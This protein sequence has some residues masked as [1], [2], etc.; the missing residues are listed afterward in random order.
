MFRASCRW[1]R[2]WLES[3]REV[4]EL[5]PKLLSCEAVAVDCE[6]VKLSRWG[7]LCLMQFAYDDD[8]VFIDACRDGMMPSIQPFLES[9]VGPAKIFHDCR[10]DAAALLEQFGIQLRNVYD[11]QVAYT[12]LLE[13]RNLSPYLI[14]LNGLLRELLDTENQWTSEIHH[15]LKT[16]PNIKLCRAGCRPPPCAVCDLVQGAERSGGTSSNKEGRAVF[17]IRLHKSFGEVSYGAQG[18]AAQGNDDSKSERC[19]VFQTKSR[20]VEKRCR[21]QNRELGAVPRLAPRRH[22]RRDCNIVEYRGERTISGAKSRAQ[23][24]PSVNKA[25][26]RRLPLRLFYAVPS[27]DKYNDNKESMV[28][29]VAC[30]RR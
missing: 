3:P 1:A 14:G 9:R 12:M 26:T 21:E 6:G 28:A 2:R 22:L 17:G 18:N 20:N 24:D 19:D 13:Q 10:E 5:L 4:H 27:G 11:T 23:H 29:V 8:V 16:D 30:S 7:R 25:A 15:A